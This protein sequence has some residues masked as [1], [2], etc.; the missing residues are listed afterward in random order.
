MNK[1]TKHI[2]ILLIGFFSFGFTIYSGFNDKKSQIKIQ[3]IDNLT[4]DFDF[5]TK[6]SYPEDV[7]R[8][9]YGQLS[10]D[11]FCPKETESMKDS[12]G[13]IN[14]DSLIRFYRLVDT[15]HQFHSISCEAWCYE[16][17]GTYFI[18]AKQTNKNQIICST[19]TNAGTH[20]SL[21][22][23]INYDTCIPRIELNPI[24]A[25][26]LKTYFCKGGFIKIDRDSWAKGI[27]KAEFNFDFNN[28]DEPDQK[29]FWKGKIYTMI[30][31][32]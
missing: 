16:W 20:C 24:S 2:L 14:P 4:G 5:R 25:P 1:L 26:G 11:G 22:F 6:W 18:T 10:C 19:Q 3:W 13:K 9:K 32:L 30:E 15:T 17:S 31:K 29:M 23:E 28:K 12:D 27:L 8:N 7:Y 21:I